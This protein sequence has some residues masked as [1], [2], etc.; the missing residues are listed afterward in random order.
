MIPGMWFGYLLE[1]T[2]IERLV[3]KK[4]EK[5]ML[6]TANIELRDDTVFVAQ[7]K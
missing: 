2:H 1:N 5:I 7:N 4:D 3:K 6:A